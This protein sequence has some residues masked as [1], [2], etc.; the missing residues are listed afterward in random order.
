MCKEIYNLTEAI[1]NKSADHF[2]GAGGLRIEVNQNAER[3]PTV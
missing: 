1:E 3:T 2:S